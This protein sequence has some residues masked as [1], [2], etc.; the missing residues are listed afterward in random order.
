MKKLDF[1][2]RPLII[3]CIALATVQCKE[4]EPEIKNNPRFNMLSAID[5]LMLVGSVD[6]KALME[7]SDFEN[8]PNFNMEMKMLYKMVMKDMMDSE[9]IGIQLEG[10][11]HFAVGQKDGDENPI[12]VFTAPVLKADKIKNGVKDVV[13]GK[14]AAPDKD[15][16]YHYLEDKGMCMAWDEKD[17]IIVAQD[18]GNAD[19]KAEAKRLLDARYTDAPENVILDSY[20]KRS[21][22]M[23]IYVDVNKALELASKQAGMTISEE[24]AATF[25][26]AYYVAYGNFEV[27]SISFQYE[28]NAPNFVKS[29]YNFV[30]SKAASADYLNY[31]SPNNKLIGFI[32]SS[33]NISA[34]FDL[35]IAADPGFQYEIEDFEKRMGISVSQLKN[36]FDGE[37][38]MSIV[39]M[40]V[41]N[42]MA[43]TTGDDFLDEYY[44]AEPQPKLIIT[45]GIKDEATLKGILD[46]TPDLIQKSGYYI[47]N[48]AFIVIKGNKL[49][50]STE[51]SVCMEIVEKGKLAAYDLPGGTAINTPVFGFMNAN[52]SRIPDG[53]L[54]M[55]A[56]EQGQAALEFLD[57]FEAIT[58][59]GTIEKAEGKAVLKDKTNNALKVMVDYILA[60]VNK[61]VQL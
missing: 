61:D 9:L 32:S 53:M 56:D 50:I 42:E 3:L 14:Y 30:G 55:A 52:T 23:N 22:D 10:N 5:N 4:D 57:L 19:V 15:E 44:S 6:F 7:K 43:A 34:L 31:I 28:L 49:V 47:A 18:F 2:F 24:Y 33:I 45:F 48:D 20:L 46:A 13:K 39:D 38:A 8:S 12:I 16:K 60:A 26:D 21:D 54:G 37:M 27:G 59:T 51:E 40:V 58:V 35:M 29:D 36:I 11:N 41:P 25:K 1:L 17:M